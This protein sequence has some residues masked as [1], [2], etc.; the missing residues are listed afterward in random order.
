LKNLGNLGDLAGLATE[1]AEKELLKLL[2]ILNAMPQ[3]TPSDAKKL[4]AKFAEFLGLCEIFEG[5]GGRHM[6]LMD[7]MARKF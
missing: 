4:S 2:Q 6:Q 5:M 3:G 1:D 7:L